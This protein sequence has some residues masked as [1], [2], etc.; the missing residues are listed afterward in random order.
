MRS[1]LHRIKRYVQRFCIDATVPWEEEL[2]R[3]H[4]R[5]LR[6]IEIEFPELDEDDEEWDWVY[7]MFAE[8]AGGGITR[9]TD[10]RR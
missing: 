1:N 4:N 9:V 5:I 2:N 7:D 6:R 3:K 8:Q 10:V